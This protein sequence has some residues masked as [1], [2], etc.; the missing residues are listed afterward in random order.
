LRNK[1][2]L[3]ETQSFTLLMAAR[4]TLGLYILAFTRIGLIISTCASGS[5]F[6]RVRASIERATFGGQARRRP[7]S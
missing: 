6:L 2:D 5:I 3:L 7:L 1:Y 4:N